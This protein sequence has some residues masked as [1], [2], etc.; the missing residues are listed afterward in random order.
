MKR[1]F[2]ECAVLLGIV[3]SVMLLAQTQDVIGHDK[4]AGHKDDS[5]THQSSANVHPVTGLPVTTGG[6]DP[7]NNHYSGDCRNGGEPAQGDSA[8]GFRYYGG[9]YS[10]SPG[11]ED[12]AT[13]NVYAVRVD[14]YASTS[15]GK[16]SVTV[17]PGID[18]LRQFPGTE[19]N[20]QGVAEGAVSFSGV[21]YHVPRYVFGS[22]LEC[23]PV[24]REGDSWS[25]SG[26]IDLDIKNTEIKE[27]KKRALGSGFESNGANLTAHSEHSYETEYVELHARGYRFKLELKGDWVDWL[28]GWNS[29]PKQAKDA[30]GNGHLQSRNILSNTAIA[31]YRWDDDHECPGDDEYPDTT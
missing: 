23:I 2:V 15:A 16:A 13:Q 9:K 10:P 26:F 12:N 17:T 4:A 11:D 7:R 29:A 24:Y 25:E 14:V 19:G 27:G 22:Y 28:F 8:W 1:R 3:M 31:K 20:W 5:H 18:Q 6:E 21:C 30:S